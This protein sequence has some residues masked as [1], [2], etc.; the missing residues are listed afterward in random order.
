MRALAVLVLMS[1]FS[2]SSFAETVR[3]ALY[4]DSVGRYTPF[5]LTMELDGV[6]NSGSKVQRVTLTEES[7]KPS[8]VLFHWEGQQLNS[9][10]QFKW[11]G[12]KKL[13]ITAKD[14]QLFKSSVVKRYNN[15]WGDTSVNPQDDYSFYVDGALILTEQGSLGNNRFEI[16]NQSV[17]ESCLWGL[18]K[19]IR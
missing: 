2:L 11:V 16:L 7:T 5:V 19:A 3:Y 6:F 14:E 1:L 4:E 8:Q 15:P 18:L 12:K 17:E 9:V 13:Q 10:F